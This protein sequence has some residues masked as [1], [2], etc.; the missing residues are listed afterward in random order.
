MYAC[1]YVSIYIICNVHEYTYA[2]VCTYI[3]YT[4]RNAGKTPKNGNFYPA[5]V[6]VGLSKCGEKLERKLLPVS[7]ILNVLV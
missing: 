6:E 5:G 1:I 3:M 4:R 2:L 7:T